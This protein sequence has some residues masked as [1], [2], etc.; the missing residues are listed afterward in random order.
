MHAFLN[1]IGMKIKPKP[2]ADMGPAK[3]TFRRSVKQ[4]GIETL[5]VLR[6]R[7]LGKKLH[8]GCDAAIKGG[9]HHVVKKISWHDSDKS[10]LECV[11]L[12]SDVCDGTDVDTA[13]ALDYSFRKIDP[14]EGSKIQFFGQGTDAGGGGTSEGLGREMRKHDRLVNECDC[15]ITTYSMHAHDVTI[16]SPSEKF[17]GSGVVSNRNCL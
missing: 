6:S 12:D 3:D 4:V 17:L 7:V 14:I 16:K 13:H 1:Q 5:V 15:M 9:L 10:E 8:C 11:V 2:F